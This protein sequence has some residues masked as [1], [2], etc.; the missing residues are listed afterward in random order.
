MSIPL[1]SLLCSFLEK[2]SSKGVAESSSSDSSSS[3]N[4]SDSNEG[5]VFASNGYFSYSVCYALDFW[6]TGEA[7]IFTV[8][9]TFESQ[10]FSC[11]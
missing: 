7:V 11:F 8:N 10:I 5:I 9:T 3:E 4:E 2:A 6:A 1:M